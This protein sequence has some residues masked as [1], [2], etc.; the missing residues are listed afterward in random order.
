MS[1]CF[2]FVFLVPISTFDTIAIGDRLA[3]VHGKLTVDRK[4]RPKFEISSFELSDKKEVVLQGPPMIVILSKTRQQVFMIESKNTFQFISILFGLRAA[5]QNKLSD[6]LLTKL[7][8]E[9]KRDL[10]QFRDNE[11]ESLLALEFIHRHETPLGNNITVCNNAGLNSFITE[12]Q[13]LVQAE[14]EERYTTGQCARHCKMDFPSGKHDCV[15]MS[16]NDS[17]SMSRGGNSRGG[18][19]G[20]GKQS[21][22]KDNGRGPRTGS[23]ASIDDYIFETSYQAAMRELKEEAGIY[24]EN[25]RLLDSLELESHNTCGYGAMKRDIFLMELVGFVRVPTK[26]CYIGSSWVR[27]C[28]MCSYMNWAETRPEKYGKF[29]STRKFCTGDEFG[30]CLR[31]AIDAINV[32]PLDASKKEIDTDTSNTALM[33][34]IPKSEESA[35]T[36]TNDAKKTKFS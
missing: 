22:W 20:G 15:T 28:D 32:P 13:G 27:I 17:A 2:A 34:E 6:E 16:T 3:N 1:N 11:L 9:V 5:L 7:L 10:S 4:G 25:A 12:I 35:D 23:G 21:Q 31:R 14:L 18:R 29:Y 26:D 24:P 19:G 36:S 8:G 30:D 33:N